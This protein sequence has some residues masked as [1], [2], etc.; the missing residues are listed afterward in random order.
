MDERTTVFGWPPAGTEIVT[1]FAALR[2]DPVPERGRRAA[3]EVPQGV[4]QPAA[5]AGGRD[6][7]VAPGGPLPAPRRRG[8]RAVEAEAREPGRPAGEAARRTGRGGALPE[9]PCDGASPPSSKNPKPLASSEE[10]AGVL[11]LEVEL[12]CAPRSKPIAPK[13]ASTAAARRTVFAFS[14]R[15]LAAPMRDRWGVGSDS[16]M[17]PIEPDE[18]ESG[19]SGG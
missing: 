5:G 2:V 7:P 3:A 10:A 6:H 16:G 12:W 1:A 9:R 19:V 14:A 15:S 4:R 13:N 11:L 8:T 18:P 17:R